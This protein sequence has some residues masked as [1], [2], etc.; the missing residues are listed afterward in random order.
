MAYV[1][2]RKHPKLFKRPRTFCDPQ[3]LDRLLD[4]DCRDDKKRKAFQ[5]GG[6][7]KPKVQPVY[8]KVFAKIHK[9]SIYTY[10]DTYTTYTYTYIDSVLFRSSLRSSTLSLKPG[11][12]MPRWWL[13]R[14]SDG[15]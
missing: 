14:W 1:E 10:T 12:K 5:R 9:C 4:D 7:Q 13:I 8:E 6:P 15:N 2:Y 11:E 3:H